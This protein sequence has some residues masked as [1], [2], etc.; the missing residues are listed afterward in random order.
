M[1]V[2]RRTNFMEK[3][4]QNSSTYLGTYTIIHNTGF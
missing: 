1:Y 3:I 2:G 4:A